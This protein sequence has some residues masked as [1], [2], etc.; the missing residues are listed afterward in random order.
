MLLKID[1]DG[2]ESRYVESGWLYCQLYFQVTK[3]L[4]DFKSTQQKQIET[5]ES[6]TR[7]LA[8]KVSKPAFAQT[9]H[10]YKWVDKA[11]FQQE[12]NL[13]YV[14]RWESE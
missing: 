4:C 2:V 3:G 8:E 7:K 14:S 6:S 9:H 1:A 11:D 12:E 5:S 10:F 13:S